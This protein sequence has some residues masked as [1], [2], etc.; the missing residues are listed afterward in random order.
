MLCKF[1]RRVEND[2]P[3]YIAKKMTG[4]KRQ[5]ATTEKVGYKK[6]ITQTVLEAMN[7]TSY[8]FFHSKGIL[9]YW[10]TRINLMILMM[11]M[12]KT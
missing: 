10:M 1:C 9:H 12:R 7:V 11:P 5:Y 3:G 6:S 2:I 8:S 4:N